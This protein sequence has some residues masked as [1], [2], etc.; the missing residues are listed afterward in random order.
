MNPVMSALQ[1]FQLPSPRGR[2]KGTM[3]PDIAASMLAEESLTMFREG[4]K[5]C[6]NQT[7][8]V[9]IRITEKAL[10]RKSR[11]FSHRSWKVVLA[12]GSL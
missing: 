11:A 5:L 10:V 1:I 7:M 4:L 2:K 9:A 12:P 6:R 8:I 3:T